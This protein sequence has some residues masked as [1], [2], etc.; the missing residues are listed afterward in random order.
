MMF[1]LNNYFAHWHIELSSKCAL[2]CP[3]CP[4]TEYQGKYKITELNLEFFE[5]NF[6]KSFVNQYVRYIVFCGGQGDPIYCKD[7]IKIVKYLKNIRKD[8]EIIIITNGSYKSKEWW[9]ELGKHL[10]IYDTVTF[11]LDGWD[12]ESNEKYR[13]NSDWAS[14]ETG[15]K[16]MVNSEAL[17]KWSMI[18]FSFNQK[19]IKKIKDKAESLNID[20]LR[21]VNS[22]TFGSKHKKYIDNNLKYDPLEPAPEFI[23]KFPEHFRNQYVLKSDKIKHL[24]IRIKKTQKYEQYLK[25]CEDELIEFETDLIN[26]KCFSGDYGKYIDAEGI[27]YPC[28][29]ISHPYHSKKSKFFEKEINFENS[30]W[31]ENKNIFNLHNNKIEDVVHSH[32]WF[33]FID[34]W[35]YKDKCFVECSQKCPK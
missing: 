24:P 31:V 30:L 35:N 14:I 21:I 33:K 26:P 10:N 11:S 5:K 32:K 4:R 29:W 22:T 6:T 18:I 2:K 3:R 7:L 23:G 8:L 17:V 19:H 12:Q 15:I 9:N 34:S 27:L 13:I 28:S 20:Q 1:N 16:E 25:K